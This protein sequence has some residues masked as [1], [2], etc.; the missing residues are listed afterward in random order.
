M[1]VCTYV[2]NPVIRGIMNFL[3]YKQASLDAIL[4]M[5][6]SRLRNNTN[7]APTIGEMEN[8]GRDKNAD[9]IIFI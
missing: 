3:K 4:V 9:F 6:R 2:Q 8:A 5:T 7:F 1:L